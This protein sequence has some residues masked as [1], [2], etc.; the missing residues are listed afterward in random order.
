M[1]MVKTQQEEVNSCKIID[2]TVLFVQ[3]PF[4]FILCCWCKDLIY[5]ILYLFCMY[6]NSF[7]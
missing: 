4:T 5:N 1:V 7:A 2:I 6:L 3:Q